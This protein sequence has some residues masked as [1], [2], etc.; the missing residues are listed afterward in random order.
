[1]FSNFYS[2]FFILLYFN[3]YEKT[4]QSTKLYNNDRG[5]RLYFL[6]ERKYFLY[7]AREQ[8]RNI[9]IQHRC[10]VRTNI[11]LLKEITELCNPIIKSIY[12]A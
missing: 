11:R 9:S 12:V 3:K 5:Y 2:F 10:R 4:K 6:E 8:I 1:M 7:G